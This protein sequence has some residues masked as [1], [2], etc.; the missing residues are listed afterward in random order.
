MSLNSPHD[1]R[2]DIWYKSLVI[3]ISVNEQVI[4]GRLLG[5]TTWEIIDAGLL[6]IDPSTQQTYM[7]SQWNYKNAP[8]NVACIVLATLCKPNRLSC[9]VR[10]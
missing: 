3:Q 1:T 5:D 7:N 6:S 10:N 2:P 4:A 9:I 8:Q